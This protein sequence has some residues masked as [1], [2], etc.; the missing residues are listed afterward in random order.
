MKA[1]RG[2]PRLYWVY[3]YPVCT[4]D[5]TS[6]ATGRLFLAKQKPTDEA[7]EKYSLDVQEGRGKS[8]NPKL[9]VK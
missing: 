9:E 8:K 6:L 5:N 1:G 2:G 3:H 7:Y 4:S